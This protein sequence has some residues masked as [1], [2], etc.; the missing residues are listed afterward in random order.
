[1]IMVLGLSGCVSTGIVKKVSSVKGVSEQEVLEKLSKKVPFGEN[2]RFVYT[3][4]WNKIPVGRIIAEIQDRL[5]YKGREVFVVK[6]VTESN[7]F[8]SKIYRVEDTY[9][10]YVDVE[11]FTS[12]RY[13]ANRKEGNYR[14][15]VVVEYDFDKLEAVYTSLTDGTV[16][17]CPIN[18][19]VHD[20][21]SAICF[22]MTLPVTPGDKIG[23]IVN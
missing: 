17:K 5:I 13:E 21:L 6:L 7:E 14:K 10:S 9:T 1:M 4:A 8:L 23:V 11:T 22:F 15:H 20:P 19:D 16:K 12:R 2:K 18:I 3:M